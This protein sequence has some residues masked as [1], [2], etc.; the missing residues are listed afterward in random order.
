VAG[1]RPPRHETGQHFLAGKRLADRIAA[2]AELT[3]DDFVVEIGAGPGLLTAALAARAGRVQALELDPALVA[4]ARRRLDGARNVRVVHADAR[5]FPL[6]REPFRVVA[7]LP[8]SST[9]AILRRLL[10]DPRVPMRRAD[11][12][13]QWEVARKRATGGRQTLL[14]AY[15][16]AWFDFTVPYRLPAAVFNPP[17][18]VDAAMLTITRREPL[19]A[20]SERERFHALLSS[21]FERANLPL[22]QALAR[23]LS[24]GQRRRL[25]RELSGIAGRPPPRLTSADWAAVLA[26]CSRR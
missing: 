9:T 5:T 2:R 6:P 19:V 24:A 10:D 20:A 4:R 12:V 17:P 15:W 22:E 1:R 21:A 8:F 18:S 14:S 25:R 23:H 11:V 16:G 7:S 26:I 3:S 13:V